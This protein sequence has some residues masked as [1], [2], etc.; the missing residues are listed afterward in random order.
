M[1][2]T[3][4]GHRG[5]VAVGV[6]LLLAVGVRRGALPAASAGETWR[7]VAEGFTALRCDGPAPACA[8]P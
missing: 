5:R 3:S 1:T 2:V 6:I 7:L 4:G 8:A